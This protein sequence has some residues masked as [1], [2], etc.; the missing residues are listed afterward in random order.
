MLILSL[1]FPING[2]SRAGYPRLAESFQVNHPDL[3]R[4]VL[5]THDSKDAAGAKAKAAHI[6]AAPASVRNVQ[7]A[8]Q[9]P[10]T[11]QGLRSPRQ[12]STIP[13]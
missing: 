10:R 9:P 2:V 5:V 3:I 11:A 4:D 8:A 7:A 6:Y 1:R 12:R 13:F